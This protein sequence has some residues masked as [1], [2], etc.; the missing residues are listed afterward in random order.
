MKL[1]SRS[2][3]YAVR[4][5]CH[6]ANHKDEIATVAGL[7]RELE[8]PRPFLRK[9]LQILNSKGLLRSFKGA[10]GGFRLARSPNAIYL[11]NLI[12]IFQGPFSLN[13]CFFKKKLCR[14]RRT[15][16][17][18]KKIDLIEDKVYKE[19]KSITIGSIL[20]GE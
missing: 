8:M 13:E 15:C 10:D 4:A 1:L 17:L 2:T 14:N 9:I 19:L 20:R 12:R 16:F 18:K 3:D 5:L 6:M 7:V 11:V